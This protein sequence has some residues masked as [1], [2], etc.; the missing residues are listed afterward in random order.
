MSMLLCVIGIIGGFL[1][2]IADLLL[3]LKGNDNKKIGQWKVIDSKWDV[4]GK[5]R[6]VTSILLAMFAVPM[7]SMGVFALAQQ[8]EALNPDL[9]MWLKLSIYLGSMGGFFIHTFACLMPVIYKSIME[10][11][12]FE[13]ADKVL[14]D[15]FDAVQVPFCTLYLVLMLAP[16]AIVVYAIV[17]R[18]L[19]VPMWFVL[20]NPVVFQVIGWILRA[21]KREWFCDVPAVC[22]ASLG[23]AMFG[24]IGVVN[25]L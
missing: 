15:M 21:L 19:D 12:R 20:L 16:T 7:Y 25:L 14:R 22:S 3:D 18:L 17:T 4:M 6:F 1:C 8:I 2:A 9:A 11:E 10:N 13:L 24:V 5:G 23:L